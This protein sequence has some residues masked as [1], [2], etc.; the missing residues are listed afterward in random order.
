MAS[1]NFDELHLRLSRK[2]FDSNATAAA[3]GEKLTSAQRTDY[4][5]RA[6][7]FIQQMVVVA[8]KVGDFL[9]GLIATQ[10]ITFDSG[11]VSVASD[12]AYPV[13]LYKASSPQFRY[14]KPSEKPSLDGNFDLNEKNAFTVMGNKIFAYEN[15]AVLTSGTGTFYYVKNDQRA[16][17]GDTNDI[18]INSIWYDC[19][20]DIA[21]SFYFEDR[22][23][24]TFADANKQR[25]A[26]VFALLGR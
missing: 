9:G 7:R 2:I 15:G 1:A 14:I 6:N 24:K 20:V 22:G 11:G 8:D 21:A 25:Q 17:S 4:L 19:V 5:N 18:D 10:S 16:S 12:Y 23:E 3:A 13:N 26:F